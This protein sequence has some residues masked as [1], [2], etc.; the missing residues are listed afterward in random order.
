MCILRTHRKHLTIHIFEINKDIL[1][2]PTDL[3]SRDLRI[4]RYV[5]YVPTLYSALIDKK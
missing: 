4:Y 3:N 2:T 5:V 1:E